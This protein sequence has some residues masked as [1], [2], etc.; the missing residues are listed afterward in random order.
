ARISLIVELHEPTRVGVIVGHARAV[1][2]TAGRDG[3]VAAEQGASG[4]IDAPAEDVAVEVVPSD[5]EL[6]ARR[7]RG[8]GRIAGEKGIVGKNEIYAEECPA[9]VHTR[10]VNSRR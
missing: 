1:L 4:G 8:N 6:I 7:G 10:A 2:G 3:D 5:E 9:R